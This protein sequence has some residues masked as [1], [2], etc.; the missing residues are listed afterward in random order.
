MTAG[1]IG[2]SIVWF[3]EGF[4]IWLILQMTFLLISNNRQK[5]VLLTSSFLG[6][7]SALILGVLAKEFVEKDFAFIEGITAIIASGLLFWTAWYCHG[8]Q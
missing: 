1:L 6:V 7:L 3:R 2:S 5:I 4:E 8:A